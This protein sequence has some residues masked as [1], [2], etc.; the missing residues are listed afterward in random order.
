MAQKKRSPGFPT[1]SK[2]EQNAACNSIKGEMD[3]VDDKHGG[4]HKKAIAAGLH[5][6]APAKHGIFAKRGA[7]KKPASGNDGKSS[8]FGGEE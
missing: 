5:A 1:L 7:S 2:N 3:Q 8:P 6:A 4:D